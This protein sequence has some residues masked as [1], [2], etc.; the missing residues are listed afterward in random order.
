MTPTFLRTR[1]DYDSY[2]DYWRLVQL[3]GFPVQYIDEADLH[4]RSAAYI[5]S[6]MNGEWRPTIDHHFPGGRQRNQGATLM[7]W[8]LERPS[9]AGGLADYRRN[10]ITLVEQGY[11]DVVLVSDR[12]L[13]RATGA[14]FV[15]LGWHPELGKPGKEKQFDYISLMCYSNH[16]S[17]FFVH[18]SQ[19]REDYGG[20][21]M[22]PNGWAEERDR[23]LRASRFMLNVHQDG[24]PYLEP[25][26][27]SLALS[28]GL[29]IASEQV[30]DAYPYE[31]GADYLSFELEKCPD[32]LHRILDFEEVVQRNFQAS[33]MRDK[34]MG[35]FRRLLELFL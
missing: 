11:A 28:Y 16:R 8:N 33:L 18:P 30:A 13:A 27:W 2:V 15:P 24:Q 12:A 21:R 10:N 1:Y 7:F 32:A 25:L 29:P 20:M 35:G 9:G 17:P 5:V 14:H 19:L 4:D 22:A 26:R 31:H 34:T 3:S 23:L 6:P